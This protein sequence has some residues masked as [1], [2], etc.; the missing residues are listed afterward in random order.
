MLAASELTTEQEGLMLSHDG[1]VIEGTMSNVFIEENNKL[2]TP[3][4]SHSGVR[5]VM[6]TRIQQYCQNNGINCVEKEITLDEVE[7]ATSLFVCNSVIGIWPVFMFNLSQKQIGA[8]TNKLLS[9]WQTG[10]L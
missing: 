9:E 7:K 5:G 3:L 10:N 6:R 2:M 1:L 8:L 4:L